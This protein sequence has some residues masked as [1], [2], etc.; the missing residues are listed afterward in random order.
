MRSSPAWTGH[1]THRLYLVISQ[2][3]A[4]HRV[5]CDLPGWERGRSMNDHPDAVGHG[6]P[7]RPTT[8]SRRRFLAL[9]AAGITGA[10]S[11]LIP[12]T[13]G[14]RILGPVARV[15]AC[16]GSAANAQA[17]GPLAGD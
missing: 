3:G 1:R 15:C 2:A 13:A 9:A 12:A 17:A 8:T 4:W 16:G 7:P 5:H 11:P 14:A 6:G 10:L